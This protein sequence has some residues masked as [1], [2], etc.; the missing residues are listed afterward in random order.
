MKLHYSRHPYSGF[1][2]I[3][4][5]IVIAILGILAAISI[6]LYQN[7]SAQTQATRVFGEMNSVRSSLEICLSEGFLTPGTGI[8]Q[9]RLIYTCS[10]LISGEKHPAF[11]TCPANTGVPQ[12]S[13]PLNSNLTITATFGHTAHPAL[14]APG[15]N[16][17][18]I[19][20]QNDGTWRCV[21][22]I[23]KNLKPKG[24]T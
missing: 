16:Q 1:T 22:T 4:V 14:S 13:E 2:L 8:D 6:P 24:C 23:P 9:C 5:M 7:Y 12:V 20:R 10:T 11:G 19:S 18:T 17:L 15:N 21:G 3:E